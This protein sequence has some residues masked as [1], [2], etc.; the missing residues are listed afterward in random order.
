MID[1]ILTTIAVTSLVLMLIIPCLFWIDDENGHGM[2]PVFGCIL[3]W[4]FI[5]SGAAGI[6]SS[7]LGI[8]GSIFGWF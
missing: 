7:A 2:S 8:I 3:G 6:I 1:E 5:V 4:I